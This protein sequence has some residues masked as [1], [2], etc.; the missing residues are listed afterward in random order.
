MQIRPRKF[1]ALL[2][3][4]KNQETGKRFRNKLFRALSTTKSRIF[5][6]RGSRQNQVAKI[7][8][9]AIV[10]AIGAVA[11]NSPEGR[12]MIVLLYSQ[13]TAKLSSF[14]SEP[15]ESSSSSSIPESTGRLKYLYFALGTICIVANSILWEW[16]DNGQIRYRFRQSVPEPDPTSKILKIAEKIYDYLPEPF[17]QLLILLGEAG[18]FFLVGFL[19]FADLERGGPITFILETIVNWFN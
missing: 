9:I 8:V 17:S 18:G 19:F 3:K 16:D 4:P 10:S 5:G 13:V 6:K 11:L 2:A 7:A 1:T 12:K 15:V 14:I